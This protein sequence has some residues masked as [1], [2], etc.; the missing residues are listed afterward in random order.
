MLKIFYQNWK[1]ELLNKVCQ[2][3]WQFFVH[4]LGETMN[5]FWN[6]LTF[7]QFAF[8]VSISFMKQ[9][10]N[11]L[12]FRLDFILCVAVCHPEAHA[13]FCFFSV[14]CPPFPVGT[15]FDLHVVGFICCPGQHLRIVNNIWKRRLHGD[16]FWRHLVWFHI[17]HKYLALISG[18]IWKKKDNEMLWNRSLWIWI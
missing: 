14:H 4:V 8:F 5:S 10:C 17:V 18:I 9:F 16:T 12:T 2:K 6:L 3:S 11:F 7:S 15:L 13:Y 1:N